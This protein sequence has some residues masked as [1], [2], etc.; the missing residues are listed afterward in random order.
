MEEIQEDGKKE[1]Q[2][3]DEIFNFGLILRGHVKD[4]EE[5]KQYLIETYVNPGTLK[6][7]K[8][9]YDKRKLYIIS[10]NQWKKNQESEKRIQ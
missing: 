5:A 1:R 4:L 6:L 7:I 9:T 8:P 2:Y 10:E 3:L